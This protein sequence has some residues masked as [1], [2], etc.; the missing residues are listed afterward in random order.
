ML[1][2][3]SWHWNISPRKMYLACGLFLPALQSTRGKTAERERRDEQQ[4][5]TLERRVHRSTQQPICCLH[6]IWGWSS[7]VEMRDNQWLSGPVYNNSRDKSNSQCLLNSN[8]RDHDL[9]ANEKVW[10]WPGQDGCWKRRKVTKNY[11]GPICF[12]GSFLKCTR[13]AL[14]TLNWEASANSW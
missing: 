4:I 11:I 14:S 7:A 12:P 10:E 13:W 8:N 2:S 6:E 3:F 5:R 9:A 1:S